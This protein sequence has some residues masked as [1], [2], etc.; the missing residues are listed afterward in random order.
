MTIFRVDDLY[1]S[2]EI[3]KSLK[4]GNTGGVRACLAVDRSI[5]RFV[6]M[7]NLLVGKSARENPYHDRIEG[8]VLIY[9]GAGKQG[10]QTLG[11]I[12][13][14]IP[15]QYELAFPIYGFEIIGSRRDKS[16]GPKRWR[17]LGLL[18][19]LRHYP[20]TQIDA[21][22]SLRQVW[23]FE[24]RLH[25]VPNMIPV[26]SEAI[27]SQEIMTSSRANSKLNGDDREI[28]T[29]ENIQIQE[30]DPVAIESLRSRLLVMRPFEFEHLI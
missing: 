15:Q 12:N 26:E 4:V 29:D 10:D 19:Y 17:F 23:L 24:F 9:T 28:E 18:E 30:G 22:G 6:L 14:R 16:I 5:V 11:G 7:I 8:D 13:K 3:Q 21:S 1:S 25:R 20:D 2:N 27:I